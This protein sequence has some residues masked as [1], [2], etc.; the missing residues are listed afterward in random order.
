MH[1]QRSRK[2]FGKI[3]R[4]ALINSSTSSCNENPRIKI[5]DIKEI[6]F[7]GEGNRLVS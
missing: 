4:S 1:E 5:S 2:E 7:C 6:S 3:L